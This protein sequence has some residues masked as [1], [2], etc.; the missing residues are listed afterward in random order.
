MSNLIDSLI[1]KIR[2]NHSGLIRSF[3]IENVEIEGIKIDKTL[4]ERKYIK[5]QTGVLGSIIG[6]IAIDK[7]PPTSLNEESVTD[8][9]WIKI[10]MAKMKEFINL[11][12]DYDIPDVSVLMLFPEEELHPQVLENFKF[13]KI[14]NIS[15]DINFRINHLLH[16]KSNEES[17]EHDKH[18]TSNKSDKPNEEKPL[19]DVIVTNISKN[20]SEFFNNTIDSISPDTS[21]KNKIDKVDKFKSEIE[22]L[23]DYIKK[24]EKLP[25][26]SHPVFSVVNCVHKNGHEKHSKRAIKVIDEFKKLGVNGESLI[27]STADMAHKLAEM[28]NSGNIPTETGDFALW[29]LYSEYKNLYSDMN[30]VRRNILDKAF[31][32][33]TK[34]DNPTKDNITNPT[35]DNVKNDTIDNVKNDT[36]NDKLSNKSNDEESQHTTIRKRKR[37]VRKNRNPK[38]LKNLSE[39]I[40]GIPVYNAKIVE[41]QNLTLEDILNNTMNQAKDQKK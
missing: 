34:S 37:R 27:L 1:N 4:Y 21:S 12:K 16:N 35:I 31:S 36:E 28:V 6:G 32:N 25:N 9:F 2:M 5:E 17:N 29:A 8:N 41:S 13:T 10:G 14:L 18:E 24:N 7:A 23:F 33:A 20:I 40:S 39:T 22:K 3:I 38:K 19:S 26:F 11:T 30:R 15:H